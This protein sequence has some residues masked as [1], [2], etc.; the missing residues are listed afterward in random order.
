MLEPMDLFS[1]D[2]ITYKSATQLRQ[3]HCTHIVRDRKNRCCSVCCVPTAS[4]CVLPPVE[5]EGV[6]WQWAAAFYPCN[7]L[8]WL[9]HGGPHRAQLPQYLEYKVRRY[10]G[11]FGTSAH[12]VPTHRRMWWRQTLRRLK[13]HLLLVS[14]CVIV[15]RPAHVC[16]KCLHCLLL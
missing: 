9:F 3:P 15:R 10:S 14:L 7:L 6:L 12:V 2:G 1:N 8:P 5:V 11:T 13:L 4:G 16:E